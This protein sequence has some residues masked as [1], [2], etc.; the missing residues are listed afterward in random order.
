MKVC[1]I[2][3]E[4][5]LFLTHRNYFSFKSPKAPSA[6]KVAARKYLTQ[7]TY[8]IKWTWV[9]EAFWWSYLISDYIIKIS[10][11]VPT[12]ISSKSNQEG[13]IILGIVTHLLYMVLYLSNNNLNLFFIHKI[14]SGFILI[15][16]ERWVAEAFL[17][18][19]PVVK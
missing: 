6:L 3:R 16:S 19:F 17:A 12:Q 2:T 7:I 14:N 13:K 15:M 9:H 5:F 18:S 4:I 10:T 11:P 8:T 1:I